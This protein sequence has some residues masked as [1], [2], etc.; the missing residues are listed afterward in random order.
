MS[1]VVQNMCHEWQLNHDRS[2]DP[3]SGAFALYDFMKAR[4]EDVSIVPAIAA[5]GDED[6]CWLMGIL[7][8]SVTSDIGEVTFVDTCEFT[9]NKHK[10]RYFTTMTALKAWMNED[11]D[12]MPKEKQDATVKDFMYMMKLS[13][14]TRSKDRT[15]SEFRTD[16]CKKL[17][18]YMDDE[19]KKYIMGFI[20]KAITT[21]GHLLPFTEYIMG[22]P[23]VGVLIPSN[24]SSYGK[25]YDATVFFNC[26]LFSE[27]YGDQ[28]VL[29][30]GAN[31]GDSPLNRPTTMNEMLG[32][33]EKIMAIF[34][35]VKY[36]KLHGFDG[37]NMYIRKSMNPP[38]IDDICCVCHDP[39]LVKT[40]CSH[41]ICLQCWG[42]VIKAKYTDGWLEN[43]KGHIN[44]PMC[45]QLLPLQ[46]EIE[47]EVADVDKLD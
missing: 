9:A 29:A 31:V 17:K 27:N 19:Y 44:C 46:M 13:L 26:S 8:V 39:C 36:D 7:M 15:I 4:G 6:Y 16:S 10:T 3:V 22:V 37:G 42:S 41:T 40:K 30:I 12:V 11:G 34:R 47:E 33:I 2:D 43:N 45:R 28:T 21:K 32:C 18:A 23:L 24:P 25:R 35:T 5:E 38:N 14:R 1:N 20:K